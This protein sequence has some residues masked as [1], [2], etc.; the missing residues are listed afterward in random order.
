MR[1]YLGTRMETNLI[2]QTVQVAR[3]HTLSP[4]PCVAASDRGTKNPQYNL[5]IGVFLHAGSKLKETQGSTRG[6]QYNKCKNLQK[7]ETL[8]GSYSGANQNE[9]PGSF[10][11]NKNLNIRNIYLDCG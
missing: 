4:L 7:G 8:D 11:S 5:Q 2:L 9:K 6:N 3:G 1:D 10:H